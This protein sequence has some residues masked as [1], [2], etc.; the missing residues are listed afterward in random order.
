MTESDL[1]AALRPVTEAFDALG[2]RY[3]LW[4]G[5]E[6]GARDSACES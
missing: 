6:L 2:V 5:G 3:Y 4:F 1:V